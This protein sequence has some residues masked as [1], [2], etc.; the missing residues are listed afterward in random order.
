MIIKRDSIYSPT[1]QIRRLHIHLPENYYETQEEYP[2]VYFFD[3]HNLFENEEATYGKSWGLEEYLNAWDKPLIIVG[4]E[5]GHGDG[6]RLSEYLPYKTYFGMFSKYEPLGEATFRWIIDEIKPMIDSEYRAIPFR[7]C[8]AIA[9]SSC[10][11]IMALYGIVHFNNW[12]SKGA[13][14]STAM[15]SCMQQLLEDMESSEISTDTRAFLS[16]GTL[17]AMGIEDRYSIDYSSH[18]YK[19]NKEVYDKFL[20]LGATAQMYCQVGGGH[21]E[22]DWEK[23]VPIFMDFLWK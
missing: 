21:C 12:F 19:R 23:L 9:G 4:I 13:C 2:V 17:E 6:E 16:W 18:T 14:I 22:A 10:G 8:T 7:E 20:S 11:G 3:G 5:C 1:G 15:G